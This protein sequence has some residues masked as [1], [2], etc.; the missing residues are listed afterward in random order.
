MTG[1]RTALHLLSNTH[2]KALPPS[3][4]YRTSLTTEMTPPP[5]GSTTAYLWGISLHHF[6]L[7]AGPKAQ[8]CS[9]G[10]NK[11]RKY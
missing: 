7:G 8:D 6:L 3:Q 1:E 5:Q 9:K 2:G 4:D 11:T 10:M